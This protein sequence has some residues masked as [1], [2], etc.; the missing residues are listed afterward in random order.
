MAKPRIL[1]VIPARYRS[2]RFPGKPLVKIGGQT[3]IRRVYE[4]ARR[5]AEVDELIVATDDARIEREISGFGGK[6]ELTD[7][8]HANGTLRV[9]E[10]AARHPECS[11]VLNLQG[12]EPLLEPA[13]VAQLAERITSGQA[14]IATLAHHSHDL[15]RIRS[16]HSVKVLRD[17]MGH[18]RYFSR[19]PLPHLAADKLQDY[20]QRQGMLLHYGLYAFERTLLCE[21]LTS[22]PEHPVEAAEGLEQLRWLMHGHEISVGLSAAPSQPVDVPE[23]VDAVLKALKSPD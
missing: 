9:A 22:L 4:R 20:I 16:V 2:R 1:A 5:S 18:A 8:S 11:Y 7:P 21:R 23:D 6:V 10:V 3:M 15:Q 13:A 19:A 14:G 17:T 12:D